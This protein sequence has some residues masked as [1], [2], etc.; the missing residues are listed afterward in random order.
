MHFS[1]NK[2]YEVHEILRSLLPLD[3]HRQ[4]VPLPPVGSEYEVPSL[5]D[6]KLLNALRV[7]TFTTGIDTNRELRKQLQSDPH[8]CEP[9]LVYMDGMI[10]QVSLQLFCVVDIKCLNKYNL[11]R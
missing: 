3:A 9:L 5:E 8:Y 4:T 6:W 1:L 11:Y 7:E 10:E 2:E